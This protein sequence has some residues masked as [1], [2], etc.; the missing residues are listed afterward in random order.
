ML[1][2]TRRVPDAAACADCYTVVT[3]KILSFW[4]VRLLIKG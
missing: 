4:D 2:Q 3:E 1:L